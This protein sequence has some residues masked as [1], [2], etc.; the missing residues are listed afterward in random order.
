[1]VCTRGALGSLLL[2]LRDSLI[3]RSAGALG[4]AHERTHAHRLRWVGAGEERRERRKRERGECEITRADGREDKGS[5]RASHRE[6]LL[7]PVSVGRS[8]V[9]SVRGFLLYARPFV[10]RSFV[11]RLASVSH[12]SRASSCPPFPL[13]VYSTST[14]LLYRSSFSFSLSPSRPFSSSS[15]PSAMVSPSPPPTDPHHRLVT[16]HLRPSALPQRTD[17]FCPSFVRR[18]FDVRST[19]ARPSPA[20]LRV[21]RPSLSLFPRIPSV[22]DR[23][24]LRSFSR[25]PRR[26]APEPR[27]LRT[28]FSRFASFFTSTFHFL[29]LLRDTLSKS[30]DKSPIG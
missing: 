28:F 16:D 21:S 1:M 27:F 12:A 30:Y 13:S 29:F 14:I 26:R 25:E 17:P 24:F 10:V 18:S 20:G 23:T 9:R 19:A 15:T 4:G 8:F 11:R 2:Q 22:L 5:A 3:P 7:P 6:G